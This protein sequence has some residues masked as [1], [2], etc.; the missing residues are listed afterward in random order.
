[1]V[2]LQRWSVSWSENGYVTKVVF[3]EREHDHVT[4]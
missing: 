4:E 2:I 3:N 1:M